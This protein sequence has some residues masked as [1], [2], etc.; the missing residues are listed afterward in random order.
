MKSLDSGGFHVESNEVLLHE[1]VHAFRHATGKLDKQGL[2]N[3]LA[4]YEDN[5]EFNAVL[6]QGIY[7][8]ERKTP[9]RASH[10]GKYELHREFDTSISFFKQSTEAFKWVEKFCNDHPGF[11]RRLATIPLRFNPIRAYYLF[12]PQAKRMARSVFAKESDKLVPPLKAAV[13]QL[14]QVIRREQMLRNP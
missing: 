7:A 12:S 4:F 1:L 3:G 2:D 9:V 11:T 10:F 13:M 6:M 14:R 8:S 5:E